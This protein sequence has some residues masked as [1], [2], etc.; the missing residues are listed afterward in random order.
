MEHLPG[1]YDNGV[2]SSVSPNKKV[3]GG[4]DVTFIYFHPL[5]SR[6]SPPNVPASFAHALPSAPKHPK[7]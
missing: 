2:Q 4:C 6:Q 3:L 5:D 1:V 7:E